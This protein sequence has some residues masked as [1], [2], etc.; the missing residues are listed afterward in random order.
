MVK[1][2]SILQEM[3]SVWWFYS[4]DTIGAEFHGASLQIENWANV[5]DIQADS[6]PFKVQWLLL[7]PPGFTLTLIT[8]HFTHTAH[9]CV[10]YDTHNNNK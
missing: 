8:L 2:L 1:F 7:I 3:I 5:G 9:L 10:S 4:A 6:Q